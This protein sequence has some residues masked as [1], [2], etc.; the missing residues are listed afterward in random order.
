MT[1]TG[2]ETTATFASLTKW[3]SVCLG[4]KWKILECPGILFLSW[5]ILEKSQNKEN[6]LKMPWNFF[7]QLEIQVVS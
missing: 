4:A 2:L 6:V 3:F 5:K 1:A 7:Y